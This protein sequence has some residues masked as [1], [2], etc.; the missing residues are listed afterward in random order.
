MRLLGLFSG[1]GGFEYAA[2]LMGWEVAAVCEWD[3]F[4][5]RILNYW[6]PEAEMFG[7]IDKTDFSKYANKIDII[8]GGFPCQPFSN[9][10]RQQGTGDKRYKW[11]QMFSAIKQVKP[12]YVLA[13]NVFGLVTWNGGLVLQTVCA[14]LESEGYQVQPFIIPAASKNAPH[15][16]YRVW[17]V[18]YRPNTGLES[19]QQKRENRIYRYE[20]VANTQGTNQNGSVKH[21]NTAGQPRFTNIGRRRIFANTNS[22]PTG[23]KIPTW[24]D[25]LAG[26]SSTNPDGCR[27]RQEINRFGKTR[28]FNGQGPQNNWENFPTQPPVCTG[29][30]GLSAR[31]DGITFSKWRRKSIE[32]AGNAVVPQIVM[33]F[34]RHIAAF[35]NQ[36]TP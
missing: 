13:E 31:L 19:V 1:Q 23:N 16:R 34:Y 21:G 12:R 24:R 8:T 4:C 3:S 5:Q 9:S 10:G 27:L 22:T 2:R 18:A 25:I 17:I 6:F 20:T 33:E 32:S 26:A 30:D 11:P 7:D 15:E 29:N 36:L 14:D 35:D 28:Q